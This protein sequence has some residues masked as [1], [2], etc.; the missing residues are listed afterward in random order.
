MCFRVNRTSPPRSCQ[1]V[2]PLSHQSS[3]AVAGVVRLVPSL[4]SCGSCHG[5]AC[6]LSLLASTVVTGYCPPPP[7][8]HTHILF[9]P[10]CCHCQRARR[11]A[12]DVPCRAL[13]GC[14]SPEVGMK[15][16]RKWMETTFIVFVF[17]FFGE[18]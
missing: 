14:R 2:S 10:T 7:P 16:V 5:A 13:V 6:T 4:R 11:Q 3:T 17:I 8:T 1:S 15:T 9:S 18:S 12:R